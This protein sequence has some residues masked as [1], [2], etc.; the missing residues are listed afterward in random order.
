[1]W[2]FAAETKGLGVD[3]PVRMYLREIGPRE[4]ANG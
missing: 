3:D 1:M 4:A 2:T